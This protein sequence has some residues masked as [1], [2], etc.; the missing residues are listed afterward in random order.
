MW[1]YNVV[2]QSSAAYNSLAKCVTSPC[3]CQTCIVTS[4]LPSLST[5]PT[6][7]LYMRDALR[8]WFHCTHTQ[9]NT[10][11]LGQDWRTSQWIFQSTLILCKAFQ[12]VSIESS[13]KCAAT[14]VMVE[15]LTNLCNKIIGIRQDELITGTENFSGANEKTKSCMLSQLSF[16]QNCLFVR[17]FL[18]INSNLELS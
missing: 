9:V 17:L 18:F 6:K 8:L 15:A 7:H 1:E 14:S 10:L 13:N 4:P 5:L 2:H 12:T 3:C 11:A 16:W